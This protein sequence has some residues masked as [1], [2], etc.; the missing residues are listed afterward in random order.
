MTELKTLKD[1]TCLAEFNSIFN[2]NFVPIKDLKAEAVKW[3]KRF[4]TYD[5]RTERWT[6]IRKLTFSDW[7]K[8]F[9]LSEGDLK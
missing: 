1:I 9:N 4:L 5:K 8:F 7:M 2:G 3:I 6:Q